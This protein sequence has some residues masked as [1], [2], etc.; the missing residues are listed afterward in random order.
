MRTGDSLLLDDASS[1]SPYSSDE[2]VM[3]HDCRSIL[4]LPLIK[5]SRMI[6]VLYL[7]NNLASNVFTP[8]RTVV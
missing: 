7:E 3:R 1:T 6:G 2:Y 8:P 4:C 5:R